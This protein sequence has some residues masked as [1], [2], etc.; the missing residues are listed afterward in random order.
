MSVPVRS[1]GTSQYAL[2]VHE[3]QETY[4][5]FQKINVGRDVL[6]AIRPGLSPSSEF[7]IEHRAEKTNHCTNQTNTRQTGHLPSVAQCMLPTFACPDCEIKFHSDNELLD[8]HISVHRTAKH[9]CNV[10]DL[11]FSSTA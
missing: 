9:T 8:H 7:L 5:H 10:S 4:I 3:P 11:G 2:E 1:S 6:V